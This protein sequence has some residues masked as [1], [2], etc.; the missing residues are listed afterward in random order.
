M[1]RRLQCAKEKSFTCMPEESKREEGHGRMDGW[2]NEE[3]KSQDERRSEGMEEKER[4]TVGE[5]SLWT[6]CL[7]LLQVC[8]DLGP[9]Q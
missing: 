2:R 6:R 5:I 7:F 8:L 9:T 3:N 4:N 1:P